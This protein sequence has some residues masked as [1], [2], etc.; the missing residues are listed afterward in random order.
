MYAATY[1]PNHGQSPGEAP[2]QGPA[3]GQS[4]R[5]DTAGFLAITPKGL[6]PDLGPPS[7]SCSRVAPAAAGR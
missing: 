1:T 6:G 5:P 4:M 7:G 2:Q 3:G